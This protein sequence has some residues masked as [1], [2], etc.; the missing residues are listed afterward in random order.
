MEL[1]ATEQAG[2]VRAAQAGDKRVQEAGDSPGAKRG[3]RSD[4]RPSEQQYRCLACSTICCTQ[5][6]WATHIGM[7]PACEDTDLGCE[8]CDP[9]KEAAAALIQHV[10][11][12]AYKTE[13]QHHMLGAYANLQYEKLVERTCIQEDIKEQLVEPMVSKMKDEIYR[14]LA[15]SAEARATLDA[16]IGTV[17]EVHQGIETT[18]KEQSVL[19][20]TVRPIHPEMRELVDQPDCDGTPTGPRRGDY[21]YDVPII[22]EL[23]A[24]FVSDPE[25]HSQLKAASDS[26]AQERPQVGSTRIVYADLADGDVM[27]TH[28]G[29]Q[30]KDDTCATHA[31]CIAS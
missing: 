14:R 12:A 7:N 8:V 4:N 10:G 24:L 19:R 18:A 23:Q 6:A 5:R 31:Q 1:V 30:A 3:R 26:W 16:Q 11:E 22:K 21:V 27:K 20:A 9:E 28:P 13:I 17:F 15:N 2:D 29:F 25:L